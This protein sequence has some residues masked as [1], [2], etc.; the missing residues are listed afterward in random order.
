MTDHAHL[1]E[2]AE[3]ATP[4]PWKVN[5]LRNAPD[6]NRDCI[7]VDAR[8]ERGGWVTYRTVAEMDE[9]TGLNPVWGIADAE[10]IA[11]VNPDV[12]LAL[13]DELANYRVNGPN[14]EGREAT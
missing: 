11:A 9:D 13:L 4:G 14:K 2:L 6:G 1:R 10:Y 12:V 5:D 8:F 3:K 7:W